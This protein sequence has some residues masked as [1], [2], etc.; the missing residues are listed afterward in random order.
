[1]QIKHLGLLLLVVAV[2]GFNFVFIRLGLNG[3]PPILL[4]A[5]RFL[6]AAVPAVFFL[7]RPKCSWRLLLSYGLVMFALQFS[8]LFSAMSSGISPGLASLMMQFQVFFTMLLAVIL[9]REKPSAGKI[10]GAMISFSG[11][12]LVAFHVDQEISL[13]GILLILLGAFSW[14][15]GNILSKKIQVDQPLA[16]VV[17]GSLLASPFLFLVSFV[18]EG[19]Q[20]ILVALENF[21]PLSLLALVYIV[22]FSTHLA[23]AL[24]SFLLQR[25]PAT[26]V[27]PFTLLVPVFGFIGSVFLLG[28]SFP[29]WK[30]E[31]AL[32]VIFG[33]C[34]PFLEAKLRNTRAISE[35]AQK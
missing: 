24:W 17:W 21:S 7:R 14:G 16:L 5:F 34:V 13:Q 32:L 2:W 28:E 20:K 33:L 30:A 35:P 22:Y 19:P 10:L 1:M 18:L 11:I 15:L 6:L 29:L 23:Y 31:A 8:F 9:F 12:L 3:M 4:C 25:Y 27:A 26:T